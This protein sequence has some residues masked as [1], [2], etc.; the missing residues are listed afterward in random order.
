MHR[1]Y[2]KYWRKIKEWSW[3]KD[4]NTKSLFLHLTAEAN[5]KPFVFLGHR[6]DRGQIACGRRQLAFDT[7]LSEQEVRTSLAKLKST[8]DITIE[9]TSNFSVVSIVNYDNYQGKATSKSTSKRADE[10]PA[11]NQRSTTIKEC[12][13]LE[14]EK[15]YDENLL[16]SPEGRKAFQELTRKL[17][18][19]KGIS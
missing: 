7:G 2:I 3:Y 19:E 10:Q 1:G 4:S 18:R 17:A 14:N 11:I 9:S 6:I 13:K 16:S 5:H 8:S 15:N 12:K